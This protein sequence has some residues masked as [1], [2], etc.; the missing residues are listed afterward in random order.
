MMSNRQIEQALNSLLPT[1]NNTLPPELVN[2]ALSLLAQSRSRASSLKAEEEI[3]RPYACAEIA[4]KRYVYSYISLKNTLTMALTNLVQTQG[5]PQASNPSRWP[6]LCT[7]RLQETVRISGER[8][9]STA[10]Q[11]PKCCIFNRSSVFV[12]HEAAS[13]PS[14]ERAK[15]EDAVEVDSCHI[16]YNASEDES[17]L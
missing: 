5:E 11:T 9:T 10:N 7:T 17:P 3:A 13:P 15:E 4:C 2:L 1:L 16:E 14:D 6:S 8:L 12:A